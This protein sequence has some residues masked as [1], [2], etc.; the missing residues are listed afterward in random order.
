MYLLEKYE[1]H[2]FLR[3]SEIASK[4]L[5][6]PMDRGNEQHYISRVIGHGRI[7]VLDILCMGDWCIQFHIGIFL[8]PLVLC[9]DVT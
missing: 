2:F 6:T 7:E 4:L 9:L 1:H 3:Q 5:N 8:T